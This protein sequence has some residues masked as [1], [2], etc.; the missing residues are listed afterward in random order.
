MVQR[1]AP[2][3]SGHLGGAGGQPPGVPLL[4]RQ[5]PRDPPHEVNPAL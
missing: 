4:H 2:T 1:G 3:D 5:C